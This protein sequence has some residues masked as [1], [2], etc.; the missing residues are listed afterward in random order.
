MATDRPERVRLMSSGGFE[1]IAEA[2]EEGRVGAVPGDAFD[3][4]ARGETVIL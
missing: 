3:W 4:L 1:A 2:S